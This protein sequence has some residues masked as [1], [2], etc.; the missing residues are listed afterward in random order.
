MKAE[1]LFNEKIKGVMVGAYRKE[2]VSLMIEFATYKCKE[3]KKICYDE[4]TSDKT[5]CYDSILYSE[6]P[7]M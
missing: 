3:Q 5:G 7:K 6:L 2:I 4:I 1:E